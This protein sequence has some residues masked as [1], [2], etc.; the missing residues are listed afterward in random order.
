MYQWFKWNWAMQ[1]T[2]HMQ[3]IMCV[4]SDNYSK[5]VKQNSL[6]SSLEVNGP[7][8]R[9]L[10]SLLTLTQVWQW[11][12]RSKTVLI[13]QLE[14]LGMND[15]FAQTLELICAM[16]LVLIFNFYQRLP[17]SNLGR[18]RW[19]LQGWIYHDERCKRKLLCFNPLCS[20]LTLKIVWLMIFHL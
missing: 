9:W 5:T 18:S 2:K 12:L 10:F 14:M 4:L 3:Y 15:L 1:L 6:I 7:Q 19:L 17:N 8:N 16:G 13:R 20:D 11:K